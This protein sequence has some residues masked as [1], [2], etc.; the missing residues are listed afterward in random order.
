MSLQPQIIIAR[1]S[2]EPI[3]ALKW[4]RAHTHIRKTTLIWG[5][6]IKTSVYVSMHGSAHKFPGSGGSENKPQD[7]GTWL[8]PNEN[9]FHKSPHRD[10]L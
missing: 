4:Q 1:E 9:T 8:E 7:A 5:F 3:N 6:A 2:G 10:T